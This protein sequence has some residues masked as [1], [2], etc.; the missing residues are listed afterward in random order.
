MLDEGL[1]IEVNEI[2]DNVFM[3]EVWNNKRKKNWFEPFLLNISLLIDF[4][5]DI[6]FLFAEGFEVR[7][8]FLKPNCIFCQRKILSS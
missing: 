1:I 3:C 6:P 4:Q 2:K 7:V 8:T 5:I